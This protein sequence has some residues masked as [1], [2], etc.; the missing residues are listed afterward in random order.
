M[1]FKIWDFFCCHKALQLI[2]V[3]CLYTFEKWLPAHEADKVEKYNII[4]AA[5]TYI[6]AL[7]Y[8]RHNCCVCYLDWFTSPPGIGLSTPP[9]Y[10]V[11]VSGLEMG[12]ITFQ[13]VIPS[14]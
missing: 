2:Y 1:C 11:H 5:Y 13:S 3:D 10:K 9:T 12:R 14:N 7:S 6:E 4:S 8:N